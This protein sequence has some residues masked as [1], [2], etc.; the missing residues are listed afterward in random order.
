MKGEFRKR[1]RQQALRN[2]DAPMNYEAILLANNIDVSN[3]N[4]YK[5]LGKDFESIKVLN[6][7]NG[8]S[9]YLRYY[10]KIV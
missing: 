8:K 4:N 5:Y 6:L 10:N 7:H 9:F 2:K 3:I 1:M